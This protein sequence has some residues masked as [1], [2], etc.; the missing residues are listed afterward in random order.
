MAY[1][2]DEIKSLDSM[3]EKQHALIMVISMP[4]FRVVQEEFK[5]AAD[6]AYAQMTSTDSPTV[7]AKHM[8]Q[9]HACQR[10]QTWAEEEIKRLALQIKAVETRQR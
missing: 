9:F 2:A 4:G 6:F 7:M 8:G 1:T 3:K 10:I 5:K